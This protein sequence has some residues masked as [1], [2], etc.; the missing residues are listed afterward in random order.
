MA[1]PQFQI[2]SDALTPTYGRNGE[3]LGRVVATLVHAGSGETQFAV[4]AVKSD[5]RQHTLVPVPWAILDRYSKGDTCVADVDWRKLVGAPHCTL[6]QLD[7]FDIDL[8]ARID[9]AY[10]LEFPG[11]EGLNDMA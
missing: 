8:A 11:I 10:G 3:H 1:A 5:P 9:G 2:V 6:S 4:L 7:H